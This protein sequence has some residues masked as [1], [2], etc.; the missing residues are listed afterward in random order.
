M[1]TRVGKQLNGRSFFRVCKVVV[2]VQCVDMQPLELWHCHL[3]HPAAKA[4]EMLNLS[5]FSSIAA[6]DNKSCDVC[7]RSKQT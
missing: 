6:F 4:M 7:I 3:G 1:V 2:S 5:D